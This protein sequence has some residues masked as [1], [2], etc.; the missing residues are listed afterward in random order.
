MKNVVVTTSPGFGKSG[1]IADAIARHGWEFVRCVDTDLPDGGLS[2]YLDRLEY[3]VVGLGPATA[4]VIENAPRLR[5]ILK[6][7]VAVD[8]ID[9]PAATARRVPVLNTPGANANAVAELVL[10]G[11]IALSRRLP[12]A[13]GV[14]IR[15]GWQRSVGM[16][17]E[18]KTLG[19][20]GLGN[21]GRILAAKAKAI[22][23]NVLATDLDPNR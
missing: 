17:I 4:D 18:G 23:M 9:I 16:E 10:C 5:A 7:G 12:E 8:N 11:M 21:V 13:H 1:R 19:I 3:L 22:G 6:H 2:D 20:V 15:G 14:V